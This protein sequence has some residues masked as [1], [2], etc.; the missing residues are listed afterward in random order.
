M[1]PVP[2][3]PKAEG[4]L[5][6]VDRPIEAGGGGLVERTQVLAQREH[7]GSELRDATGGDV[8][9]QGQS[10]RAFDIYEAFLIT[11]VPKAKVSRDRG[12]SGVHDDAAHVCAGL[13]ER[14]GVDASRTA[15]EAGIVQAQ[16]VDGRVVGQD[17]ADGV[18]GDDVGAGGESDRKVV[19]VMVC[20]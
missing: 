1:E 9:R 15:A 3:A 7:A 14:H 16:R 8:G 6:F 19:V 20:V 17:W 2:E 5:A 13:L 12:A 10:A 18:R 11:G 4:Q